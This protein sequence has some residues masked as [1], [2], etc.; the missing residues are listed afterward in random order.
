MN[1]SIIYLCLIT[2][3]LLGCDMPKKENES[4]NVKKTEVIHTNTAKVLELAKR[5]R[6]LIA[7]HRGGYENDFKDKAPENSIANIQNAINHGFD[8][9]ETDIQR[10]SDG[11][12][13]IMHDPT[14]DRTTTGTG[15]VAEMKSEDI[16]KYYLKYRNGKISDEKIPFLADFISGGDG[17]IIFKMDFKPELKYLDDLIKEI[18][19]LKLQDRVIL[20]F[21]YKKDIAEDIAKLNQKDLPSIL[22]RVNTLQQ[23]NELRSILDINMVSV[24]EKKE[25]NPEELQIINKASKAGL[26]IE[27]HSFNDRKKNHEDYWKEELKLPVKIIHTTKPIEMK[28]LIDR[29]YG[30]DN[31]PAETKK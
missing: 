28:E 10:T 11:K 20:R 23:Y 29:L 22:F 15:K 14:I 5:K 1:K 17:H 25:F 3:A 21:K 26:I 4:K 12:F 31:P 30:N 13:I 24:F 6:F 18:E 7:A 9:Y 2:I 16:K 8:I 27:V 19:K